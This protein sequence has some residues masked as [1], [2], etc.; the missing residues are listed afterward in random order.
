MK[1]ETEVRIELQLSED[2]DRVILIEGDRLC[3]MYQ[4]YRERGQCVVKRWNACEGYD[5]ELTP[6]LVAKLAAQV[7]DLEHANTLLLESLDSRERRLRE[8][9]VDLGDCR[10]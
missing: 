6:G 4:E 10:L 9:G 7:R 2:E 3:K 5:G 1:H 8:C